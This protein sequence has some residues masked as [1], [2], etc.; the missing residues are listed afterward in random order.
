MSGGSIHSG[1][2]LDSSLKR[3]KSIKYH[4]YSGSNVSFVMLF[5]TENVKIGHFSVNQAFTNRVY[6][7]L[8]LKS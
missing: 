7:M 1:Y 6:E 8:Y 2:L 5:D 3:I 4:E